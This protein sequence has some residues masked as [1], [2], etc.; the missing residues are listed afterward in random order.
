MPD[1]SNQAGENPRRR[2]VIPLGAKK[3]TSVPSRSRTVSQKRTTAPASRPRRSLLVRILAG[4]TVAVV[5][6][7]VLVAGGMFLWW[8]H[9]KTK[10][11][12][13]LAVLVDAAQRNDMTTVQSIIDTD[14]L[15]QNFTE[16]VTDKAASRYGLALGD[17]AREQ[18]RA[19][20]PTLMPRMKETVVATLGARIKE[21]SERGNNK[22]FVLVALAM[23]FVVNISAND[24]QSKA[25]VQMADQPVKLEMSR[26]DDGWKVVAYRDEALVQR[27]IDQVI[28]DLPAIG[29]GNDRKGADG[30]K[31]AKG[32][33]ALR[34]Q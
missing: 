3:G 13:S 14:Q 2:I 26:A 4:L 12:Y 22:P 11:A 7:L 30:R 29:M 15:A 25:T 32:L 10:P 1:N 18:I 31:R 8:Q 17:N 21:I 23:P 20:T 19:L 24:D 34:V 28:K 33:P 16:E 27:A 6:V 5:V 9:Y